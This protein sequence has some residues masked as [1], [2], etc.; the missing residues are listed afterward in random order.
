[1]ENM[2]EMNADESRLFHI[3]KTRKTSE[4]SEIIADEKSYFLMEQLSDL[5]S[6]LISWLPIREGDRVL[7]IGS[8]YG[9][10]TSYLVSRGIE[11]SC[12]ENDEQKVLISRERIKGLDNSEARVQW[13]DSLASWEKNT[14]F[15][16]YRFVL[17]LEPVFENE[18]QLKQLLSE[19]QGHLTENGEIILVVDNVYGLKYWA[20]CQ[21]PYAGDF[22]KGIEGYVG[23]TGK[24]AFSR[25]QL[26]MA[27]QQLGMDNVEYYYPYPDRQ[28]PMQIFSDQRLPKEGELTNNFRN[29]NEDR[30][31]VFDESRVY[32]HLIRDEKF[33]D[34]TNVYLLRISK[35]VNEDAAIYV[36]YSNDREESFQVRT[37]IVRTQNQYKVYKYSMSKQAQNHISSMYQHYEML[38]TNWECSKFKINTTY[39][40]KIGLE[41]E[42]IVGRTFEDV[43]DS[44]LDSDDFEALEKSVVGFADELKRLAKI[45]FAPTDEFEKIFGTD[46]ASLPLHQEWLCMEIT[47]VDMI[48]PNVIL[49]NGRWEII[50]YEW[51]YTFP[52]PIRYVLFRSV[53]YYQ[54]GQRE[55]HIKKEIDLYEA[56]GISPDEKIVFDKM[57]R[58][59]QEYLTSG[60]QPLWKLYESMA[61]INFFPAGE[62]QR[63]K[64][65][66]KYAMV[67]VFYQRS[68]GI[69]SRILYAD[70]NDMGEYM[71]QVPVG[72]DVENVQICFFEKH[73]Y[74]NMKG[75]FAVGEQVVPISAKYSGV[76]IVTNHIVFPSD[77]VDATIEWKNRTEKSIYLEWRT[78]YSDYEQLMRKTLQIEQR[79]L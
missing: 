66:K 43:L 52:I 29:F 77:R 58:H 20:G 1:M 45:Q 68:S 38:Q 40:H 23:Y 57:E 33:A 32:D 39:N 3:V 55:N 26:E 49:R 36:K 50:D 35:K 27:T 30:M 17:L 6:N 61:G 10:I 63:V 56:V 60:H 48:F 2:P 69:T 42:Y 59:F 37:D 70:K 12:I 47:D 14:T 54:E 25:H 78:E 64:Q 22:Y 16:Q 8:S 75:I 24:K 9:N 67:K 11:V 31:I 5:R 28:F 41:H 65:E 76:E 15:E 7:E 46:Y 71:M 74:M 18:Q 73:C 72:S 62:L 79:E 19:V 4:F 21:D 13:F 51:T 53:H 44:F 34:F